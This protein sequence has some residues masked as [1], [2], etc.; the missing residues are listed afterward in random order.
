MEFTAKALGIQISPLKLRLLVNQVRGK[1]ALY[2][3]EW[4]KTCAMRRAEPVYKVIASAVA[5]AKQLK[6]ID[7]SQLVVEEIRVDQGPVYKYFKPGAMGRANAQRRKSSHIKVIVKSV[8]NKE[9]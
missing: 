4:L 5:N 9:E 8:D 3:L 1:K 6:N 7:V 2:A